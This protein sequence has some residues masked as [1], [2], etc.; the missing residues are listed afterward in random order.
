MSDHSPIGSCCARP[1]FSLAAGV[2]DRPRVARQVPSAVL[3]ALAALQLAVR[4]IAVRRIA[5]RRI[6]GALADGARRIDRVVLA[7]ALMLAALALFSPRQSL[8]SLAFVRAELGSMAPWFAVAVFFAAGA[9]ATGAD[10]LLAR[11]FSGREAYTVVAASLL[12]ALSAFCSCGVIPIIAAM[13]ASGVPLAP[14]MAFWLSSPLMDP[15]MFMLTAVNLGL[16]FAVAKTLSAIGIGL[17]GGYAT[18][19]ATRGGLLTDALRAAPRSACAVKAAQKVLAPQ[20]PV[21]RFWEEGG[22]AQSFLAQAATT[23]WFLVRWLALAFFLESLMSAYVPGGAIASLL[24]GDGFAAIPAAVVL[25][26][27]AYLNGYAAIP[28][29]KG[30][31]ELGMSPAVGLTFMIAGAV[32]SIPAAIA[33]WVLVRPRVFAFYLGLAAIGTLAAG[34]SYALVLAAG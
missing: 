11:A 10:A 33:V 32:T 26:V 7:L 15:N 1:S 9:K 4:R 30:L 28:L 16:G 13:L 34:Y 21:W 12:G 3:A 14:V 19:A 27:P 31:I 25:G 20:P 5:V 29:V 8:T 22:R 24:G 6:V 18:L 2:D 23:G 17:L